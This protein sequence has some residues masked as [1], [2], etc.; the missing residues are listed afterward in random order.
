M[1][2]VF[3]INQRRIP[4]SF[5]DWLLLNSVTL[6]S[7]RRMPGFN[8][9]GLSFS[10]EQLRSLRRTLRQMRSIHGSLCLFDLDDGVGK[11]LGEKMQL[12]L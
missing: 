9:F 2:L 12:Y 1:K 6:R 8:T 11:E 7:I 5:P 10:K 4:I 3:Y